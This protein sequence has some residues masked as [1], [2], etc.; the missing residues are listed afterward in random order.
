MKDEELVLKIKEGNEDALE[1]LMKRYEALIF[2][3]INQYRSYVGDFSID[4]DDLLQEGNIALYE[5]A[6][7]FENDKGVKFVTFAYTII[8]R[9]II[10]KNKKNYKAYNYEGLSIDNSLVGDASSKI[11]T[12]RIYDNPKRNFLFKEMLNN[13]FLLLNSLSKE[14]KEIIRLRRDLKTYSEIADELHISVKHVDYKL[15]KI[16]K[17]FKNYDLV[18]EDNLVFN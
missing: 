6:M 11:A 3:I 15:Q 7:K 8:K 18:I 2:S 14:E 13:S 5:S 10:R 4:R 17:L 12:N 1:K 16:R 9:H